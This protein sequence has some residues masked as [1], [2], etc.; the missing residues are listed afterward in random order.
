M[1]TVPGPRTRDYPW[2]MIREQRRVIIGDH[3]WTGYELDTAPGGRNEWLSHLWMFLPLTLSVVACQDVTFRSYIPDVADMKG[4]Y[5]CT[6]QWSC[7]GL[8]RPQM[9]LISAALHISK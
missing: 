2:W 5:T 1:A 8:N 6:V 3:A 9:L 7:Q 4:L